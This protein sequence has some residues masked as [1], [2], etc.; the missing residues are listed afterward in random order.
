MTQESNKEM[1]PE[2]VA[3]SS[4]HAAL[5]ELEPEVQKRVLTWVAAKLNIACSMREP[6]VQHREEDQKG[7]A[8]E[9]S[10]EAERDDTNGILD[11]ISAVAK[12]W[13]AR[14]GLQP[15]RALGNFQFGR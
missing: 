15:E 10:A 12:K 13:M 2:L 4:V 3:M 6:Y 9:A 14:S 11:G 7:G 8:L 5:K 1:E